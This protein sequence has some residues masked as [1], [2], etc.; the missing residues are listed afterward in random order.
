MIFNA[1]FQDYR[2]DGQDDYPAAELVFV[3]YEC[4]GWPEAVVVALSKARQLDKLLA[5]LTVNDF[6]NCTGFDLP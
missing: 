2:E 6:D 4:S 1:E 3:Q 5:S